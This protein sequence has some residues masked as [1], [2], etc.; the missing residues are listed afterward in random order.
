MTQPRRNVKRSTTSQAITSRYGQRRW[1]DLAGWLRRDIT[2]IIPWVALAIAVIL[3]PAALLGIFLGVHALPFQF[4]G[5][6]GSANS[7][8]AGVFLALAKFVMLALGLRPLFKHQ[9]RG[10]YYL[11]LAATINFIGGIYLSHAITSGAILAGTVYLYWQVKSQY[12]N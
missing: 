5:V 1:Y 8:G 4:L 11:I 3:T 2:N 10:W 12:E 6:P 7:A 9:R